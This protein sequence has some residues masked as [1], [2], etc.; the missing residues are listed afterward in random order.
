MKFKEKG[1]E[2]VLTVKTGDRYHCFFIESVPNEMSTCDHRVKHSY[3]CTLNIL[4]ISST[5][6]DKIYALPLGSKTVHSAFNN[7]IIK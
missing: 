6:A 2:K 7:Q 3:S 1:K 4:H 5:I